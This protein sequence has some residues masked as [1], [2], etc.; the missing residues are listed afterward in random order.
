MMMQDIHDIVKKDD[1]VASIHE[2][3]EQ[4]DPKAEK[5]RSRTACLLVP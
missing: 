5:V 2:G 4:F 3:A 1:L